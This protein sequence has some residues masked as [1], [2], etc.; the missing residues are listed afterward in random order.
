MVGDYSYR[1]S[2]S[3]LPDRDFN[4]TATTYGNFYCDTYTAEAKPTEN[5]EAERAKAEAEEKRV[6]HMRELWK[7]ER[8]LG[9]NRNGM[10]QIR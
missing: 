5:E 7:L 8:K 10:R 4:S 9:K 3:T 1:N 2:T 6:R